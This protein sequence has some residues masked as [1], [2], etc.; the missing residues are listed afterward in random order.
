M[1][2]DQNELI[3]EITQMER[4][5]K[6]DLLFCVGLHAVRLRGY[7]AGLQMARRIIKNLELREL[8]RGKKEEEN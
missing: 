7:L 4:R 1:A 6:E 3:Y 2:I 8:I 5:I